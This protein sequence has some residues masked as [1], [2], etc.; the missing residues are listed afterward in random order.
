MFPRSYYPGRFFAPT[1]FPQSAGTAAVVL[2]V[3]VVG[4][5]LSVI[6]VTGRDLSVIAVTGYAPLE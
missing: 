1:Y 3:G 2:A 6:A 4:Y 5:D